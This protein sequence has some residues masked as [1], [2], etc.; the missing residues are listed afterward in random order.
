[1]II[2][3]DT[4]VLL[5]VLIT[6]GRH[7]R[8]FSLSIF[9]M[10]HEGKVSAIITTQ[11]IIDAAYVC[12]KLGFGEIAA[13]KEAIKKIMSFITVIPIDKEEIEMANNSTIED[14]EDACQIAGALLSPCDAI[15]SSDKKFKTYTDFPI[16]TPE[17]FCGIIT[18]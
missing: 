15:I 14:Y 8:P 1:M 3:I 16:Y 4:N 6:T 13:F 18:A 2:F 11:S 10:A 5:D 9:K 7:S 12:S 17:E